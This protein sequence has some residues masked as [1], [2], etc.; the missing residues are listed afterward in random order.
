MQLRWKDNDT[1]A[2]GVAYVT[3]DDAKV[4]E[5]VGYYHCDEED[6]DDELDGEY[7]EVWKIKGSN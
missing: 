1:K 3:D 6:F 5:A 7:I 2:V 4:L